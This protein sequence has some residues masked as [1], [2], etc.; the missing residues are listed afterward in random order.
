MLDIDKEMMK[1]LFENIH[2]DN[3]TLKIGGYVIIK[4]TLLNIF[5]YIDVTP[6]LI[7]K[8]KKSCLLWM[9][10]LKILHVLFVLIKKI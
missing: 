1:Q 5:N 6:W 2:F 10:F 9:V 4:H 8:K 7:K 3:L